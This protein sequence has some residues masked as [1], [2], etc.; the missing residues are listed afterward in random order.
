M[1]LNPYKMCGTNTGD[2][3]YIIVMTI[4]LIFMLMFLA[5]GIHP[6]PGPV[7]F[8]NISMCHINARSLTKEGRIDDMCLELCN[9]Y[10]FYVIGVSETH[11]DHNVLDNDV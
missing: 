8:N 6:H 11:L 3:L 10:E 4:I 9:I 7:S 2:L 5:G 1:S